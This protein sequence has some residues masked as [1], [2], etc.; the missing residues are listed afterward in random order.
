MNPPHPAHPSG[1]GGLQQRL[2]TQKDFG[3][4]NASVWGEEDKDKEWH[5]LANNK[6]TLETQA[7]LQVAS[8][9]LFSRHSAFFSILNSEPDVAWR[10]T[11]R[12]DRRG[13]AAGGRW[14]DPSTLSFFCWWCQVMLKRVIVPHG[15]FGHLFQFIYLCI[16]L[17]RSAGLY[18]CTHTYP[19]SHP[20]FL[21]PPVQNKSK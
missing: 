14:R 7:L 21:S 19:S 5:M 9:L 17:F 8:D 16:H 10:E 6:N 11:E 15:L 12:S 1:G 20:S 13:A 3:C 2:L 18:T 4:Q